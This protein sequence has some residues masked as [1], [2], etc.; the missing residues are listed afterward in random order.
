MF[1]FRWPGNERRVT[2]TSNLGPLTTRGGQL[3]SR[4]ASKLICKVSKSIIIIIFKSAFFL[5]SSIIALQKQSLLWRRREMSAAAKEVKRWRW[6]RQLLEGT[7][8]EGM[9]PKTKFRVGTQ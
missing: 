9:W 6:K 5:Q 3:M 4:K 8:E 1:V 2:P 7:V